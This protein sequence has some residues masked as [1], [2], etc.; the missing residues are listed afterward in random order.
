MVTCSRCGQEGHNRRS[1]N[2]PNRDLPT[3]EPQ[4][5]QPQPQEAIVQGTIYPFVFI[6]ETPMQG[7]SENYDQVLIHNSHFIRLFID[8]QEANS[9]DKVF[10]VRLSSSLGSSIVVNVGGP[11]REYD[12]NS[13]YAPAWIM[14]ALIISDSVPSPIFWEKVTETLPRATEISLKPIDEAILE[15][16]LDVRDEIEAHLKNFNVL[17]Q[18]TTIP[19]PL[20][21]GLKVD[22]YVEKVLP[23]PV[24]LLRDEVILDLLGAV[25]AP[26]P[27]PPMLPQ[28]PPTP[29]PELPALLIP[30]PIAIQQPDLATRRALMAAAAL[31]RTITNQII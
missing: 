31:K 27:P 29:I 8:P 26:P 3:Q 7:Y 12:V 15:S 5:L 9:P 22:I 6:C 16:G 17:Q 24:A 10:L 25:I 14:N 19:L 30:E 21:S 11:H 2:C 13:V 23:E 4:Q 28:R 18:G 20:S 1:V